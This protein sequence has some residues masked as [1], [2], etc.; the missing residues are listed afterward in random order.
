MCKTPVLT[1]F[2]NI[3]S[4]EYFTDFWTRGNIVP[5]YKSGDKNIAD[6]YRG[7][8]LLSCLGK[9]FT[10]ILNTRITKWADVYGKINET[11]NHKVHVLTIEHTF[12]IRVLLI[13]RVLLEPTLSILMINKVFLRV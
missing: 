11:R 13:T 9:L 12:R 8:T 1:I 4:L 5:I 2:N 6:N 7:I 10:R 3:L